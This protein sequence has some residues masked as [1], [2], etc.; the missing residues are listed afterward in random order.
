[1]TVQRLQQFG[2]TIFATMT[3][4]AVDNDAVNLGQGFPDSDGPARML[5]IAQEQIASG[6]NQYAPLRGR[7]ELIDAL[8]H[9][10]CVARDAIVVT[11]GATEAITATVLGLVE[12]GQEVIVLEPYYDAYA[13]AIALADATRV[14]VPL[15]PSGGSWD[16]DVD[17]VRAAVTDKTA[18]VIVNSPH[19]PTGSVFSRAALEGLRDICVEHDML[20]LSDEVYEYLTFDDAEHVEVLRIPGMETRTV[21]VGSAAK[22]FNATGW[23]TGWAIA[24]PELLDGV[25]HATRGTY[26][27]VADVSN[28]GMDGIE[29]CKQLPL[30]KGIAAIPLAAFTDNPEP[31]RYKVRFAFCKR[32]GVIREAVKRLNA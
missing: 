13:A 10:Y 6:N 27:L 28:T 1:M 9:H 3:Q 18:M 16:L 14:P 23:K 4:L 20:V 8:A 15:K 22:S 30:T 21:K 17:A 12:P 31:W 7:P 25:I 5:E 29:F 11:A 32:P 19:N 2:E 24:H 26:Y